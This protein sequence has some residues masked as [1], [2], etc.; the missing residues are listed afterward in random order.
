[1]PVKGEEYIEKIKIYFYKG[2]QYKH[3]CQLIEK[4]FQTNLSESNL[5]KLL[6]KYGLKRKNFQESPL[7]EIILSIDYEIASSGTN[8]GYRAMHRRMTEKYNFLV[9]RD[10]VYEIM[11]LLDP[12]GVA[13]RRHNKLK[14]R[15]YKSLGPNYLIHIDGHD[16]LSQYG[17]PIH[18]C[19]DGFSR[20]CL[21][22]VLAT[23]N[24]DPDVIGHH[25]LEYV[26]KCGGVPTIVRTDRG[27]ENVQVAALQI[28]LR[29]NHDDEFSGYK[30]YILGKS[31]R[32][33]RVEA[34]WNQVKRLATA[35]YMELFKKM[36]FEN[37]LD[38]NNKIHIQILQYCF[39]PLIR[40]DLERAR[41]E[42]N[43]HRI[44]KQKGRGID[45]GVPNILYSLPENL[46]A[47][48]HKKPVDLED[49]YK[50][51]LAHT[52][53]P[54]IYTQD[55][56]EVV[57]ILHPHFQ[58]PTSPEEALENYFFLLDS[59]EAFPR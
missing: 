23:T 38:V 32:N 28:A 15:E 55:F 4:K 20:K 41:K 31:T 22:L 3:I 16:K 12:M 24:H 29:Y 5:K 33:Q 51:Q 9:T 27:T 19:I 57:R 42:W 49:I 35:Y 30:S 26:K 44:R 37:H 6:Q 48:D 14:R 36:V 50:L 40:A 43:S 45:G 8:L 39:G 34:F 47:V 10:R 21:W 7:A 58:V 46:N 54:E 56:A 17:F 52:I 25:F 53:K 1:M 18:A 2:Y 11:K 13:D 59:I